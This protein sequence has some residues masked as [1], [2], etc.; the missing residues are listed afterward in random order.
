MLSKCA[1]T[2]RLGL[3]DPI[4]QATMARGYYTGLSRRG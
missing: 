2:E 4:I 3:A 1:L